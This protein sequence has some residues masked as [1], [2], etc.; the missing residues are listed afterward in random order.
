MTAAGGTGRTGLAGAPGFTL[1]GL[2]VRPATREVVAGEAADVL[3]PRVMQV[4]VA[5]AQ[6]RG[7]VVSRSDLIDACWDGRAVGDDAINRCI[8][9][10]RRL[11]QARGGFAILTVAR[12]GYR[13]DERPRSPADAVAASSPS[14][15]TAGAPASDELRHVTVLSCGPLRETG[16]TLDPQDWVSMTRAWRRTASDTAL[17]FGAYV[18]KARGDR[19]VAYF[20]FPEAQEDAAQRA[21]YA[22]LAIAESAP[23]GLA[24][25]VGVHAGL[26]VVARGGGGDPE[27]FG[28]ALDV[29]ARVQ[30]GASPGV[31]IITGAVH[32][33]VSDVVAAESSGGLQSTVA[34]PPVRLYRAVSAGPAGRGF[35]PREPSPFVGR[36]DEARLLLGR[37]ARVEEGE[38]QFVLAAGEAGI[39]KTRLVQE[40]KARQ[41]D[42]AHVL[43]EC[44]GAPLF[45]STPFHAVTQILRQG[46]GWRDGD[47]P[48]DRFTRLEAALA[49]AGP[50][51]AETVPLIADLL[52]LPV[53]PAYAD[54]DMAPDQRRQRLLA[55]LAAWIFA[56]AAARPLLLIV[57]DLHWVDP[58][59]V[60][61]LQT[62]ADQGAK[63]RVMLLCTARPE[64]QPPWPVRSHHTRIT[65]PGLTA[66]PMRALVEGLVERAGMAQEMVDAVVRRADGV[67]L[68]AEEL[69]RL[70][71]DGEGNRGPGQIKAGDIPATLQDSLAAR[72]DRLGAGKSV[73]QL[74]SVLGRQFTHR[75]MQ[76]VSPLSEADL[77]A[78]LAQLADAE[79]IYVRGMAPEATYQFKHALIQDAAHAGLL[80]ADRR[81]LHAAVALTLTTRFADLA[82]ARPEVLARHWT[83]AGEVDKAITAWT[84][85][86]EAAETRHAFVEAEEDYRRALALLNTT[87][88]T[89]ARDQ[90]ELDLGLAL[91]KVTAATQGYQSPE[92]AAI[93]ARNHALA[94]RGGYLGANTGMRMMAFS[95]HLV[96]ADWS[97]V[98]AYAS[99]ARAFADSL[100][101]E[102][103]NKWFRFAHA[104]APFAE[105]NHAYYCGDL[106]TAEMR[107]RQWEILQAEGDY[108]QRLS[109]TPGFCN[110]AQI[111]WRLGH[112]AVAHERMDKARVWAAQAD[113]AYE[114]LFAEALDALLQ[115]GLR[116]VDRAETVAAEAVRVSE[117]K[118]F[119]QVAGWARAA[120]GW[121]RAQRGA[122]REGAA[123]IQQAIAE[124]E[125]LQT[126][127]S[128]P[129]F[130]TFLAEAQA[131]CGAVDASFASLEKAL[132][133]NADERVH[134]PYI[135][136]CRGEL[137]ARL[138]RHADAESDFRA[139]IDEA[140]GMAAAAYS[141][142][143]ATGLARLMRAR[144]EVSAGLA[145]LNARLD[146]VT[147]G[148][149]TRDVQ[150][151][152]ALLRELPR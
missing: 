147:P 18:E 49:R 23:E 118:G 126:R 44:A 134:R 87:P 98:A 9:A 58:S 33:V 131:T 3:E 95:L 89:P 29:A 145:L 96:A 151:A 143:A 25:K 11:S 67:P 7:Q 115:V 91:I 4:L 133:A 57:E 38:G 107:Y 93:R 83:E 63:S 100:D 102:T 80:K 130:L 78:G 56:A 76:A 28:E 55:G 132:G 146:G 99:Q 135:L 141:L 73:V 106:L 75:V 120:L 21:V 129:L 92:T 139:A 116:D 111:A 27:M 103:E 69:T 35:A 48:A 61:L 59:S 97:Q 31:V 1:G 10:L 26:V 136:L 41:Q 74:G 86:G 104:M 30:E 77:Q 71:L 65:L 47:T 22:G 14:P 121:A 79:L 66:R 125:R 127:V 53:P 114:E 94:E 17:H 5:L 88:E 62:L 150:E 12:V 113:S 101:P 37:W 19:L 148:A 85:A 64:F 34:G 108:D 110:G 46:L 82:E 16:E 42:G 51:L 54:L 50:G 84:R 128:M 70:M 124:L 142:R 60:E 8:Q 90:H 39:G 137:H 105:F 32:D 45:S 52:N 24:V 2:D 149:E 122:P 123:L 15:R 36:E 109:T 40:F 13:L 112:P 138:G 144:G 20:G 43:I 72:L 152:K 81:A 140:D 68:F 6:R 119:P 117:E